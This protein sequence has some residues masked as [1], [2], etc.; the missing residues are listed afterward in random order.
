MKNI[1]YQ[2]SHRVKPLT[3]RGRMFAITWGLNPAA[4]VE[5]LLDYFPSLPAVI[6]ECWQLFKQ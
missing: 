4:H 6:E 2:H 5:G 1:H 3:S